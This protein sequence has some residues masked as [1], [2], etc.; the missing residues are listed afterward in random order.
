MATKLVNGSAQH[1][2]IDEI[3]KLFEGRDYYGQQYRA[4]QARHSETKNA[5]KHFKD[6]V[7]EFIK[8]HVKE[9]EDADTDELIELA[10][11]LNIELTKK[12]RVTFNVAVEYEIEV[13]LDDD[14]DI[15]EDDFDIRIDFNGEGA[16]NYDNT[17]ISEFDTE[18]S[19]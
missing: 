5:F 7:E 6:V 16:V 1:V 8:E 14:D 19:D 15:D 3:T 13:A 10:N 12:I 11:D 9:K 18:E 4:E 17:S 2:I